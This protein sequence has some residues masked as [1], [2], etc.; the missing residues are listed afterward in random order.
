MELA[1]L[2]IPGA[3]FVLK[4][5]LFHIK[6]FII[7]VGTVILAFFL[8]SWLFSSFDFSFRLCPPG[9]SMLASLCGAFDWLFAPIGM[10]DWRI[11]YAA[12]SGLVAKENVAGTLALF[13]GSFPYSAASAFAFAVFILTC[14]PC[15]SAIAAS[16]REVG[17]KRALLY[18]LI[19]TVSAVLLSYLAYFFLTCLPV[20]L[21]ILIAAAAIAML[22]EGIHRKTGHHAQSVH[23]RRLS[24]GVD[25]S[26]RPL[27]GARGARERH[28]GGKRRAAQS[29]R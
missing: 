13:F 23:R 16:A 22:Y 24:A 28:K 10:R 7:K 6:Q 27:K 21:P 25:V 4:S 8:A 2:Q 9:Q 11:T 3:V 15:V 17:A 1:P 19:Q 20:A 12:L 26:A 18:A 5:L 29:G 14:S